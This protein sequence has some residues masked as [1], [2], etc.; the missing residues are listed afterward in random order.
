MRISLKS[1]AM[2]LAAFGALAIAA[3]SAWAGCGDVASKSPA[4]FE[5]G[6]AGG[7]RLI[8]VANGISPPTPSSIVGLWS[9]QLTAGGAVVDFGYSEWHSDGTEIMN[10]G[11]HPASTGNFCL[12]VWA[13]TGPYS[14]HLNHFALAYNPNNWQSP[15][16]G[17]MAKINLTEDVVL[18]PKSNRFT[19]S[20]HQ[21]G[22]DPNTGAVIPMFHAVG[23]IVGQRITP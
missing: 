12:G 9:V 16:G 3:P 8:R 22:Y 13:Q 7:A 6:Q 20:F 15:G 5:N 2:G 4:V 21:E 14:Y 23:N 1:T 18:D 11:G 19:G 10:S 17:L